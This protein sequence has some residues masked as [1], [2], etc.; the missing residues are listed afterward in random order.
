MKVAVLGDVLHF[1]LVCPH[2]LPGVGGS[3]RGS[4]RR[5]GE[6]EGS[7]GVRGVQGLAWWGG[8]S[9]VRRMGQGARFHSPTV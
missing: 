8:R 1:I 4:P 3:S 9:E 6:T 2:L 7:C 5:H